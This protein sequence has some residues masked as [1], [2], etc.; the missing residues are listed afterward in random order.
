M[1]S[2]VALFRFILGTNEFAVPERLLG[3]FKRSPD[4]TLAPAAETNGQ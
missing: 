3:V 1:K 4:I 2:L